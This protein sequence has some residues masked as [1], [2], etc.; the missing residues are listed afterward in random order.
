M[1]I[2][3]VCPWN[4][5]DPNLMSGY[6]YSM[7]E[8]FVRMGHEVIDVFPLAEPP[9]RYTIRRIAA[10]IR[11]QYY[12]VDRR[13]ERLA[14]LAARANAALSSIKGLDLVFSPSSLPVSS[15]RSDVP[16]YFSTDQTFA[17]LLEGYVKN[18]SARYRREG[19]AQEQAALDRAT[20]AIYPSFWARESALNHF[21]VPPEKIHVVPWGANIPRVPER[22][23]VTAALGERLASDTLRLCFVAR[24]WARKGG[25][26]VLS[27]VAILR[28]KG[29]PVHLTI[30]GVV[31]KG[32]GTLPVDVIPSL[33][34]AN[35]AD[36]Q[37][38]MAVMDRSHLLFVPSHAEAYGQVFCE[39]AAYG[40][41]S[42]T[43]AVGGIP[44]IVRE[45][46]T[47]I[48]LDEAAAPSDFA[49]RILALWQDRPAL[50]AMSLAAR[51]RFE[52]ELNWDAFARSSTAV[53][54]SRCAT[55]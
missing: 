12:N 53:F 18:S 6:A 43:R 1:K 49:G 14:D 47:G 35:P 27:T 4:A 2:A 52:D 42:V 19:M 50:E 23:T 33:N 16:I 22:E 8:S 3:F 25:D 21:R 46:E 44:T 28:D 29:V 40:I 7:R 17:D 11:G 26:D 15:L 51:R 30:V 37:R 10:H 55:P 31:P 24:E 48:C 38:W 39:A 20:G 34:K 41:P 36:F 5:A 13:V 9:P 54:A 32:I 45:G